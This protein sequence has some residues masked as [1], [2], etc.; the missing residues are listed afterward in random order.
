[1][2]KELHKAIMKKFRLRNKL[3]K[4]RTE[5][6]QKKFKPQIKFCKKLLRTTK[7]SYYSNLD[8]KNVTDNNNNNTSCHKRSLKGEKTNLIQKQ[9]SRGATLLKKRLWDSCFP[10]NL[11]NFSRTSFL[12]GHLPWLLLLIENGK[13]ISNDTELCNILN[14][15]FSNII[16]GLNIPKKYHCFLNE[17][18]SD[19]VLSLLKAFD[20]DPCIKNIKSKKFNWTFS[21]ENTYTVTNVVMKAINNLNVVKSYQMNDIPT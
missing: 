13:K 2:T 12:L 15:F 1:M 11:A 16:S 17:M 9:S 5:T 20:N 6:N 14:G 18:D 4:Y 3:L 19:S 8:I 7:K 10:V 21:F